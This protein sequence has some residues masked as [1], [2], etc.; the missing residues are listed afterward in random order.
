MFDNTLA[1]HAREA[2]AGHE[3]ILLDKLNALRYDSEPERHRPGR[4][5][6]LLGALAGGGLV[7]GLVL[8]LALA[9]RA[10]APVAAPAP[11]PAHGLPAGAPSAPAAAYILQGF[12][13]AQRQATVSSNVAGRIESVD[14]REG[15]LVR[16]GQLL[17][18]IDGRGA[19]AQ[20]AMAESH[21]RVAQAQLAE[22]AVDVER[23]QVERKRTAMLV[24]ARML[25]A[26]AGREADL[27]VAGAERQLRTATETVAAQQ[28]AVSVARIAHDDTRVVAPFDGLVIAMSAQPGETISPLSAVG[29]NTRSGICTIADMSAPEVQLDIAEKMLERIKVGQAVSVSIDALPNLVLKGKVASIGVA[30]NRGAAVIPV[31][32]AIEPGKRSLLPDMSATVS[33]TA[34]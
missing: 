7:L 30:V 21:L 8:G 3:S 1:G 34:L 11:A 6:M 15:E 33:W 25:T 22:R 27:K 19:R 18:T 13:V 23:A 10:P 14:V 31:R 12:V 4:Q 9:R 16:K 2:A 28:D 26:A 20:V 32:I 24:E 17:A 5:R 29:S